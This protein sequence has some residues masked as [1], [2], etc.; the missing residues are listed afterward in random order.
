MK[1]ML[2]GVAWYR[3]EDYETLLGMFTDSEVLPETFEAWH[4]KAKELMDDLDRAGQAYQKV[5][6]DPK[7]FPD[8]CALQGLNMDAKARARF[9]TDAVARKA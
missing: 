3:K 8:W 5:Y 2:V 9:V 4:K 6:I 1:G 7:T